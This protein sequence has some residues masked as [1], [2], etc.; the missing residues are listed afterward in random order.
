MAKKSLIVPIRK[1]YEKFNDSLELAIEEIEN[2]GLDDMCDDMDTVICLKMTKMIM[3][4]LTQ[5]DQKNK[6]SMI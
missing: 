1:K 5:T 6:D 3:D 4:S 2:D